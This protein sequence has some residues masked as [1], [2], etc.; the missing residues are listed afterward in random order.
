M[1]EIIEI[2]EGELT[3]DDDDC[4]IIDI[5]QHNQAKSSTSSNKTEENAKKRSDIE[6]G[7]LTD[8]DSTIVIDNYEEEEDEDILRL[9]LDALKSIPI[10]KNSEDT[11][12]T[13]KFKKKH[14]KKRKK[15][16]KKDTRNDN[17]EV[18]DMDIDVDYRDINTHTSHTN[19][20]EPHLNDVD[21]RYNSI[22]NNHYHHQNNIEQDTLTSFLTGFFAAAMV[23]QTPQTYVPQP[24]PSLMTNKQPLLPTP[25]QQKSYPS[26][27]PLK[28]RK[29]LKSKKQFKVKQV[30]KA[31]NI[32]QKNSNENLDKQ[33]LNESHIREPQV[34]SNESEKQATEPEEDLDKLRDMLLSDLSKKRS[35]KTNETELNLSKATSKPSP[36]H[37]KNYHP[38]HTS[39][40]TMS[41]NNNHNNNRRI[42]PIIIRI[43]GNET[44]TTEDEGEEIDDDDDDEEEY[45]ENSQNLQSNITAFLNQA[46]EQ[47]KTQKVVAS[48]KRIITKKD[49][50]KTVRDK[51]NAKS[52]TIADLNKKS[53][54]LKQIIIKKNKDISSTKEKITILREQLEAAERILEVNEKTIQTS[55]QKCR[56]IESR[57][58]KLKNAKK[59]Q[60]EH[61]QQLLKQ[62]TESVKAPVA[63]SRIVISSSQ[64]T[65]RQPDVQSNNPIKTTDTLLHHTK[66]LNKDLKERIDN[67][68]LKSIAK[69]SF[70]VSKEANTTLA[71]VKENSNTIKP[72]LEASKLTEKK[73][74]E[75]AVEKYDRNKL[76]SQIKVNSNDVKHKKLQEFLESLVKNYPYLHITSISNWN[77]EFKQDVKIIFEE[78]SSQFCNFES[79]PS[80][81]IHEISDPSKYES[82]LLAFRGYRFNSN[83][84]DLNNFDSSYSKFYCNSIDIRRPLCPFDLHGS[85]KDSNCSFQHSNS[86]TMDNFQRTEHFLSYSP[87][88]VGITE[89]MSHKEALKRI[90]N[91]AKTFMSNNLNKMSIRDYF[92]YLYDEIMKNKKSNQCSTILS[93]LPVLCFNQ[94]NRSLGISE[95]ISDENNEKIPIFESELNQIVLNRLDEFKLGFLGDQALKEYLDENSNDISA[96]LF[97]ARSKYSQSSFNND[98]LLNVL[99]Q[100][101]EANSTNKE[102]WLLYLNVY[103]NIKKL[104]DYNEICLLAIDNCPN[105]DV[106]WTVLSTTSINHVDDIISR[107]LT[108]ILASNYEQKTFY[109]AELILYH[110]YSKLMSTNEVDQAKK[111]FLDYLKNDEF[112]DHMKTNDLCVLWLY[113]I[114]LHALGYLPTVLLS[115]STPGRVIKLESFVLP[116]TLLNTKFISDSNQL[117]QMLCDAFKLLNRNKS[118]T[119]SEIDN[120]QKTLQIKSSLPIYQNLIS[121]EISLK[122]F[123][124]AFK[125]CERVLKT[126]PSLVDL[127]LCQLNIA[128]QSNICNL[129]A[130]S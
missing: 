89:S 108:Y 62:N 2:E 32:I 95:T 37:V 71:L 109:L 16:S 66:I 107:F 29:P 111:I 126:D 72:K 103:S 83:F 27:V 38:L 68:K 11:S 127:W 94:N 53:F 93:R 39:S 65:I 22:Q 47:A 15:S 118:K 51:I 7:E 116:W 28:Q 123:D 45:E 57:L 31:E 91:H 46:K 104:T 41:L 54:E 78:P 9:K 73:L 88:L 40:S 6:S 124:I 21:M 24:P 128:T 8:E 87:Q 121:L 115:D 74:E 58:T 55:K 61:L 96:W 130:V 129:D 75:M 26:Q 98:I 20:Y 113:C 82:P 81:L 84:S 90:K 80:N 36:S 48:N 43:N 122:R 13:K 100:A 85:C 106:Y 50:I 12:T 97:Y 125:L 17:Y 5:V 110:V 99:S 86:L 59:K 44:S 77:R 10:S 69:E 102:I 49:E 33:N 67:L 34:T 117:R 18:Q 70:K 23:H 4:K 105:Y 60:Q 1:S 64:T 14:P 92:K 114:H 101:L 120:I 19:N 79:T 52:K 56:T 76:E 112:Y 25:Y 3:S 119:Q 63:T 35:L 42:E 30:Q